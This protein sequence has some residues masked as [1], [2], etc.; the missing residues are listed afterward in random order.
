MRIEFPRFTNGSNKLPGDCTV[1]TPHGAA[2]LTRVRGRYVLH[3]DGRAWRGTKG[4]PAPRHAADM[5]RMAHLAAT[6][7]REGLRRTPGAS[8]INVVAGGILVDGLHHPLH[9]AWLEELRQRCR[10]ITMA[11]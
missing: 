8:R 5:D 6:L 1:A 9:A 10:N 4:W 11:A 2:T 3:M 7:V